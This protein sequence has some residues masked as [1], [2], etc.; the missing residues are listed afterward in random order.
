MLKLLAY[1]QF[2]FLSKINYYY[3]I[4]YKFINYSEIK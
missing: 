3:Y 1:S 2:D 4:Q